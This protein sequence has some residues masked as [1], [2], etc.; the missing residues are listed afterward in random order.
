MVVNGREQLVGGDRRS[1][2]AAFAAESKRKQ[3]ELHITSAQV[4]DK[5]VTFS[6]SASGIPAHSSL[7]LVAV[8][9]DD[10]DRSNVARGENSGWELVHISVARAFAPLGM[11]LET[12]QRT[13]TLPLPASFHSHS[14]T[15]HRLV[16]FAQ[17][18]GPG[19]VMGVDTTPI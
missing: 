15:G 14:G 1:L 10:M 4:G 17:Q 16:I 19:A 13:L 6:Y 5:N 2:E 3:I 9:V 8:L 12:D 18:S 7:Q 11:L